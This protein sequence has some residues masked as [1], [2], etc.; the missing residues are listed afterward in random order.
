MVGEGVLHECL[1]DPQVEQILLLQRKPSGMVHPKL[2]EVV[3][4]DFFDL[5][6]VE[7]QLSGYN[8]CFFC[9]GVSSVG[10][11][12]PEYTRL[13]HTLT[14]N[15]ASTL[16]KL[17]PEMTFCYISGA[18][19]D[20]SEKGRPMWARVKGTTEN[21]LF[22]LPFKKVFA[23]RPGFIRPIKGLKH[24]HSF[25][26][27]INW[28]FPAGRFIAPG[29]FAKLEEIGTAMI[30]TVNLKEDRKVLE[31]KDIIKLAARI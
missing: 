15:V 2:K 9:L 27:Y 21:D 23:F 4:E 1:N 13:T 10:M 20:S 28:L 24:T 6:A 31:G 19:T 11:K 30:R 29:A 14:L 3:H 18:G 5:A 26:R 16:V 17:N 8:A 7:D 25:Y 12:E 22:A